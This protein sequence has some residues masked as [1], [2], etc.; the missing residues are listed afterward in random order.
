MSSRRRVDN[1]DLIP[2]ALSLL[3]GVG[4]FID[5]EPVAVKVPSRASRAAPQWIWP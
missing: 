2:F 1:P 4:E 3:G 5:V